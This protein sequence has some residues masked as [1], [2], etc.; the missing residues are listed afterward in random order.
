MEMEEGNSCVAVV[1]GSTLHTCA[2]SG[3]GGDALT[4]NWTNLD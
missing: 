4:L 1:R 2:E 3:R